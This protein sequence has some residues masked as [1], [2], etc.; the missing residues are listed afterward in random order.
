MVVNTSLPRR[1]R[2]GSSSVRPRQANGS[3]DRRVVS[4][5]APAMT[6]ASPAG[7]ASSIGFWQRISP[8]EAGKTET[9]R[10]SNLPAESRTLTRR[11]SMTPM[12]LMP[13]ATMKSLRLRCTPRL[14][15]GYGR[16]PQ[17]PDGR[18]DRPPRMIERN[19]LQHTTIGIRCGGC[20]PIPT[21]IANR[22]YRVDWGSRFVPR[23]GC[24]PGPRRCVRW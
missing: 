3:C 5:T 12:R 21:D 7:N 6:L 4:R 9:T 22:L 10:L 19:R 8:F 17:F 23:R 2:R 15:Y 16:G 18:T 1:D 24:G 11:T 14:D 13:H 20:R